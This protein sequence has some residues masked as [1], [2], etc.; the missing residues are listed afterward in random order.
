MNKT[1]A[2]GALAMLVAL[3][4]TLLA[5]QD[6]EILGRIYGM[7]PLGA[8]YQLMAR[9]P[10]AFRFRGGLSLPRRVPVFDLVPGGQP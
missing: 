10:N 1:L 2:L 8:Y 9:D 5:A 4:T 7:R 6:V 3:G